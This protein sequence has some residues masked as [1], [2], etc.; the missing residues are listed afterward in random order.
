MIIVIMMKAEIEHTVRKGEKYK[1]KFS[2]QLLKMLRM[3]PYFFSPE[4][5]LGS[6]S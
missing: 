5:P 4:F 2:S 1:P 6:A 3:V